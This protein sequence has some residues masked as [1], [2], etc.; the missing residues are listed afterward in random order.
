VEEEARFVYE[1]GP[2]NGNGYTIGQEMV[3]ELYH[4]CDAL[5]MPSH[6]E[7]FGMPI[8]EAGLVGI[9]IFSTEI[10]AAEEIG[11]QEV[12]T[13][14]RDARA[15]EVAQLIIKWTKESKTYKLRRRIRR[16]YTWQEI[17]RGDILPLLT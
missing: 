16:N 9:P 13:F 12:Y 8:L 15:E 1:S 6:R 4:A 11:G 5:F 17:F 14:S 7:G 3:S 10:P 2:N